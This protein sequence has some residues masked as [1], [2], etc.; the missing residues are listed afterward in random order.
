MRYPFNNT[1]LK[2]VRKWPVTNIMQQYGNYD[3][4]FFMVRNLMPLITQGFNRHTHQV[5]CAQ[6]MVKAGMQCAGINEVGHAQLF[7]IS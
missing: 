1:F 3:S 2:G 4:F 7:D 5:H 6:R